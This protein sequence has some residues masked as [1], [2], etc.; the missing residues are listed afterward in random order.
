[1]NYLSGPAKKM[2]Q[3]AWKTPIIPGNHEATRR[4]QL[5]NAIRA[6]TT[7]ASVR[8]ATFGEVITFAI[9]VED[10]LT[11][12]NELESTEPNN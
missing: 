11:I 4:N 1:M 6:L 8:N 10:L 2:F 9:A 12:A 3:A 5:A 7:T